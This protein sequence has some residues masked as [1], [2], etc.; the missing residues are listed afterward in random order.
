MSLKTINIEK[1][2]NNGRDIKVSI[3]NHKC[4]GNFI[5]ISFTMI[6]NS[7]MT[8]WPLQYYYVV[9]MNII[10]KQLLDYWGHIRTCQQHCKKL[11]LLRSCKCRLP[12][13]PFHQFL[14][15]LWLIIRTTLKSCL[16]KNNIQEIEDCWTK[17]NPNWGSVSFKLRW[18][19]HPPI[20]SANHTLWLVLTS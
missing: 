17:S 12:W 6:A 10:R 4:E 1:S 8:R 16:I 7:T 13:R 15:H 5:I 20:W 14:P 3:M 11:L 18:S 2:S 19:S 9:V